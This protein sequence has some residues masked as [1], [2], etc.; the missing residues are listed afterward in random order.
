MQRTFKT[1]PSG[2][3]Y[4][5]AMNRTAAL[6]CFGIAA[7]AGVADVSRAGQAAPAA[8][9][10]AAAAADAAPAYTADGK[11][12]FP[13]DYREWIY[14]SSG[15]GMTYTKPGAAGSGGMGPMFT[16]V[17]VNPSSYRAFAQT[18]K[19]PDKTVFVLEV[20]DS[21]DHGSIVKGGRYQTGTMGYDVEVKDETR[22]PEHWRFF[23]YPAP[24]GPMPAGNPLPKDAGCLACHSKNA[25]VE[26][27]F[28]QFY[29]TLLEIAKAKGTLNPSYVHA[30]EAAPTATP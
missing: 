13:S 14:L 27:T 3:G 21:A 16:N 6:V 23:T 18:G 11:L 20:R 8:P 19:W 24:D 29:P 4:A 25:A 30:E 22:F 9:A 28:V 2:P 12:V 5:P 1:G 7:M 17:F 10:A 26:N 15:L